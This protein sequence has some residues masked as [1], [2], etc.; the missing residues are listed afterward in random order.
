M[1]LV[2]IFFF[3]T[4]RKCTR[5]FCTA[6]KL[7]S[8][9]TT[10]QKN[11]KKYKLNWHGIKFL[12]ELKAMALRSIC[13]IHLVNTWYLLYSKYRVGHDLK[14]LST[15]HS[16]ALEWQRCDRQVSYFQTTYIL[17][18]YVRTN[19]LSVVKGRC[20]HY[21]TKQIVKCLLCCRFYDTLSWRAV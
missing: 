12:T 15:Q 19:Y 21:F 11:T 16:P 14:W 2:V 4:K 17:V 6:L 9:M 10:K 5:M 20:L 8:Q 3:D 7:I 18:I 13:F 1:F